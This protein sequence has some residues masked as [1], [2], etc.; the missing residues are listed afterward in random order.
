MISLYAVY[1]WY[2]Q[3][4]KYLNALENLL[5][6]VQAAV[7]YSGLYNK[8]FENTLRHFWESYHLTRERELPS[9]YYHY[10]VEEIRYLFLGLNQLLRE[11]NRGK[12]VLFGRIKQDIRNGDA[13]TKKHVVDVLCNTKFYYLLAD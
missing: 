2:P 10:S 13:F 8:D 7:I 11:N 9:T 6:V 1:I 3:Q 5:N 12:E 4:R